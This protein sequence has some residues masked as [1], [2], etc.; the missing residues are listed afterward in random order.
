MLSRTP[1]SGW[2]VLRA[3]GQDVA[4]HSH[5]AAVIALSLAETMRQRG[6]A[7]DPAKAAAIALVH[8]LPETRTTDL[9]KLAKRYVSVDVE[10]A[11]ED[12]TAGTPAGALIASLAR[13][14]ESNDSAEARCAHDADQLELLACLVE[15]R[16]AGALTAD[17]F[18]QWTEGA[19]GRLCTEDGRALADA[20]LAGDPGA[21]AHRPEPGAGDSLDTNGE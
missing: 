6:D 15:L 16:D 10:R 13:S 19:I 2:G 1:R 17:R 8:D 4:Q 5:R 9:H 14:Y 12:Q 21:W 3:P 20:I 11:I 7:I 18:S